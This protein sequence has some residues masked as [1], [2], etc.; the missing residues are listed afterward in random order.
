V[1]SA[2]SIEGHDDRLGRRVWIDLL[3]PG[4]PALSPLR[5]D[6]GRPGRARWLAGRRNGDEC[7]DAYEAIE[8][9]PIHSAAA[10]P[11]PWS[12]VRHWLADF[13]RE[14][15]A[16]LDDGSLPALHARRVWLD[17]DDRGRILDW[18]DPGSGG[19]LSDPDAA[20]PDLQS[21]QRLLYAVSV[22]A[23][24]GIPPDAAQDRQPDTPL[25]IPART[26]LLSL[27]NGVFTTTAALSEGIAAALN[28]PAVFPKPRRAAQIG[29]CAFPAVLM[30]AVAVG[31]ILF[32]D[33]K[34]LATFDS[35]AMLWA[36]ALG[37]VSGMLVAVV[38]FA[39]VGALVMR[40]GF[41][42]RGFGAAMVNRHGQ[43]VSRFR[44]LWRAI[45]TWSLVCAVMLLFKGGDT[46]TNID[47]RLLILQT[48]GVGLVVAAAVW[49]VLHPSRGIQDRIAGTWI[50]P[51]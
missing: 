20:P 24:L 10:Q 41:T 8:G 27:R 51:R 21:A 30:A 9:D 22:G 25:P 38:P 19:A 13:T 34:G 46:A 28:A 48:L 17:R 12:R 36:I 14:V 29:V 1:A 11:Q 43:P 4:T 5:R 2:I 23:L 39:L 40:G 7:W 37:V 26:L 50:V 44:A 35:P 31:V 32:N 45:V 42:I 18:T 47:P 49:T 16:G 6:L 3:P 15:I 33:Q